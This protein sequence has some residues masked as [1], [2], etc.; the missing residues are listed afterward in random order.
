MSNN[1]KRADCHRPGAIVPAHYTDWNSYSLARGMVPAIGV[2]CS[3]PYN[4]YDDKGRVTRTV[5]P[6][7]PDTGR[8]CVR[9][10]ERHVYAAGREVFGGA[11]K[12]GVCGDY[13]AYGTMFMHDSG[14][15]VHMGHDCADKYGAMYD[16]SA[17]EVQN[18]RARAAVATAIQR[19]ENEKERAAFL[20]LHDGL[21]ADLTLGAPAQEADPTNRGAAILADLSRKFVQYRTMS[22]K[23]IAL[24][25]KLAEEIRNPP[26][27]RPEEAKVAAPTGK[28][29]LFEGEIIS[30]K[31]RETDWGIS[32]KATIKVTTPEGV[33]LAWG[34][35]PQN[36]KDLCSNYGALFDSLKG[37]LVSVKAT[38]EAGTDRE[39]EHV[40]YD[41]KTDR[42]T[43]TMVMKKADPSFVFMSRPSM[44]LVGCTHPLKAKPKKAKA[45][46]TTETV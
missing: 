17:W 33:W 25:R 32:Y 4:L 27:P 28:G 8:C 29:V 7:C 26:A 11:G 38:L 13:F 24:A 16:L 6:T 30:I 41:V 40:T 22:E 3:M 10:S 36:L 45:P 35:L 14:D 23:Q 21:E 18:N 46:K 12:C 20:R 44:E 1:N 9:S 5:H 34:T 31:S 15:L 43:V 37:A 19:S 2:D 39:V 42:E